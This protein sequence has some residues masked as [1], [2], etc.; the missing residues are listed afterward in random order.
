[1]VP[2]QRQPVGRKDEEGGRVERQR[3]HREDR[4]DQE[5]QHQARRGDQGGAADAVGAGGDGVALHNAF[6]NRLEP[7][8]MASTISRGAR[9]NRLSA[10]AMP[11]LSDSL[12]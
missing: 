11:Q 6:H 8:A 5:G 10:A 7:R 3:Y 4:Q 2:A 12:V 9:S 1:M